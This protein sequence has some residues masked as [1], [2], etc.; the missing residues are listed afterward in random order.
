MAPRLPQI[1]LWL[2][3]RT[4]GSHSHDV[5]KMEPEILISL[6]PNGSHFL[7]LFNL[8]NFILLSGHR[9]VLFLKQVYCMP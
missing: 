6:G 2:Y 7:H 9:F 3:S 5:S 8:N 4:R 1:F